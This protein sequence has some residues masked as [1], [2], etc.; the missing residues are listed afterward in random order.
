MILFYSL[1]HKSAELGPQPSLPSTKQVI[2]RKLKKTHPALSFFLLAGLEAFL[3]P[4]HPQPVPYHGSSCRGSDWQRCSLGHPFL[5]GISLHGSILPSAAN[6]AGKWTPK[7]WHKAFSDAKHLFASSALYSLTSQ[8]Y[9]H[10]TSSSPI[11]QKKSVWPRIKVA[12][13]KGQILLP[14]TFRNSQLSSTGG[15]ILVKITLVLAHQITYRFTNH[16]APPPPDKIGTCS[17]KDKTYKGFFWFVL[18]AQ[19]S[20]PPTLAFH[21]V[22]QGV[23]LASFRYGF[24]SHFILEF[25]TDYKKKVGGGVILLNA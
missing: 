22:C 4:P 12:H 20:L 17:E 6:A 24:I 25:L 21:P 1:N 3:A 13:Q 10:L 9:R 16:P 23:F 2:S 7:V 15:W 14:W 19:L 18:T 11:T 8:V 5:G